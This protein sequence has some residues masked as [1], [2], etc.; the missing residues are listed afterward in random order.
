[1]RKIKYSLIVSDFDGTLVGKDGSISPKN[2]SAI[3]EYTSAGGKFAISTGRMPSGILPYT[4]TLGLKGFVCC[5]QGSII[6]DIETQEVLSCGALSADVTEKICWKAEESDLHIH[7][8]DFWDYYSNK[9]DE[10]LKLYESIVGAKAKLVT[11]RKMSEFVQEKRLAANKVMVLVE[12]CDRERIFNEFST[13]NFPDCDVTT[14]GRE[15]V[16]VVNKHYSKGTA[17]AFLA[18]K[19][20]IPL[21]KTIAVGDQRNDLPMIQTAGLGIAV[22]NADERLKQAADYVSEYTNEENAI[23]DVIERFGLD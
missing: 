15:L 1:M 11:D 20:D 14:S 7:V 3:A 19:F 4:K 6:M 5:C 16:E 18:R 12:R 10:A 22:R 9:D 13:Q 17:L 8:Y 23:A 21:K 2:R